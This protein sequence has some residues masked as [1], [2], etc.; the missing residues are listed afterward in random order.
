M[1]ATKVPGAERYLP[2]DCSLD[3][4]EAAASCCHGCPLYQ[5]ATQTVF[6][7]GHRDAPIMLVGEQPGDREDV[8]GLPFVGPAGR[9][10]ARALDDAGIDPD[11]TYQTNAV[12]HF[13]FTRKSGKRRI[14]QKPNRTEVVAC[15]PWLIA[16]IDSLHPQLIV[17]LGATAAQA[18]LGS[19]FRVSAHR[20][21]LIGLPQE[22]NVRLDPEPRLTATVHPSAVLRD[23]TDRDKAYASFVDDLRS[24]RA[25]LS[26]V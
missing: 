21:E 11:L 4:L 1:S 15:R 5:N 2:D 18:L 17:L 9:L 13:K 7:H 16:E 14:H 24:A 6:G 20:G 26:A 3:S 23:R 22:F 10:L 12:K 25:S 19:A 8:E